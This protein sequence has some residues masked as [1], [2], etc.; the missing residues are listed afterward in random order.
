MMSKYFAEYS[1]VFHR[2]TF[3]FEIISIRL[4]VSKDNNIPNSYLDIL[5]IDAGVI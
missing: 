2:V 4:R 1:L 5:N 3:K